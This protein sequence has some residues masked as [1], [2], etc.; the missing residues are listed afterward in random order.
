[1]AKD[2]L[3]AIVVDTPSADESDSLEFDMLLPGPA[4]RR[5]WHMESL[6]VPVKRRFRILSQHTIFSPILEVR[7]CPRIRV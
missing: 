3:V 5:R 4:D 7:R 6:R 2:N 1:M